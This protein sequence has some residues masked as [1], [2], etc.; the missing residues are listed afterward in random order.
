MQKIHKNAECKKMQNAK[1]IECK[2]GKHSTNRN[3][4]DPDTPAEIVINPFVKM[5]F[6]DR[7]LTMTTFKA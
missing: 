6:W 1:K 3:G 7:F 2:N 4:V 5:H